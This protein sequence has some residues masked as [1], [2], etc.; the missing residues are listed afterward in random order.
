VLYQALVV[1]KSEE[2]MYV[3]KVE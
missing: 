1:G 3:L 2:P